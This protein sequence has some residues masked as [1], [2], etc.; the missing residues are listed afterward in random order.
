MFVKQQSGVRFDLESLEPRLLLSAVVPVA[1]PTEPSPFPAS[2]SSEIQDLGTCLQRP[3]TP[4]IAYDPADQLEGIFDGVGAQVGTLSP[5]VPPP[6]LPPAPA[7]EPGSLGSGSSETPAASASEAT[8][9]RAVVDPVSSSQSQGQP[10]PEVVSQAV[11]ASDLTIE[12]LRQQLAETLTIGLAPPKAALA[13]ASMDSAI[14]SLTFGPQQQDLGGST[15]PQL[16]PPGTALTKI[17]AFRTGLTS[18]LSAITGNLSNAA[19]TQNFPLLV[20]SSFASL[21][22]ASGLNTALQTEFFA[23]LDTF[24]RDTVDPTDE[25]FQAFINTLSP[26]VVGSLNLNTVG[27]KVSYDLHLKLS[28]TTTVNLRQVANFPDAGV[29]SQTVQGTAPVNVTIDLLL[30]FGVDQN[31]PLTDPQAFFFTVGNLEYHVETDGAAS[32][33][34]TGSA[35]A[36]PKGSLVMESALGIRFNAPAGS[37]P[38][39][40]LSDLQGAGASALWSSQTPTARIT[41]D[42][43]LPNALNLG[44]SILRFVGSK[45]VGFRALEAF[46]SPGEDILSLNGQL[47]FGDLVTVI[48]SLALR[49]LPSAA[50]AT[51]DLTAPITKIPLSGVKVFV[52][53]GWGTATPK[54]V[55]LSSGEGGVILANG[56]LAMDVEGE[57]TSLGL[58]D[59]LLRGRVHIRV[60]S[61]NS[62]VDEAIPP[63]EFLQLLGSSAPAARVTFD[64]AD[65]V[66]SVEGRMQL[67]VGS[68][69]V[70]NGDF[71]F[72]ALEEVGG[73]GNT[74]RLDVAVKNYEL[75]IGA[76]QGTDT[77]IGF[78][79][80]E[81]TLGLLLRRTPDGQT[82][83]A[84][85]TFGRIS[86]VGI[87]KL[88]FNG[89]A[90]VRFNTM[91]LV[92]ETIAVPGNTPILVQFT[93][94]EQQG[95]VANPYVCVA[96]TML[97]NLNYLG[98]IQ[99]GGDIAIE[100]FVTLGSTSNTTNSS[101]TL[102]LD[103]LLFDTGLGDIAAGDALYLQLRQN[104]SDEVLRLRSDGYQVLGLSAAV[105]GSISLVGGPRYKN[106]DNRTRTFNLSQHRRD[107]VRVLAAQLSTDLSASLG[108][109]FS[110][111][112]SEGEL[113]EGGMDRASQ[114]A[115]FSDVQMQVRK[116]V[117]QRTETITYR[118]AARDVMVFLGD[119]T[120]TVTRT[121]SGGANLQFPTD[122]KGV[123]IEHG[124]L[125]LLLEITPANL[126]T[127]TP[128]KHKYA[129]DARGSA[130]L[131]GFPE[132]VL[133]T[134]LR[135]RLNTLG[136]NPSGSGFR[137]FS[138]PFTLCG[139]LSTVTV[140]PDVDQGGTLENPFI[141]VDARVKLN[142]FDFVQASGVASFQK[143]TENNDSTAETR[144]VTSYR[145]HG[146]HPGHSKG[147][148]SDW[149]QL[150]P[151]RI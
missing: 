5:S 81:G 109:P 145:L 64:T 50:P 148:L 85:D 97:F 86:L 73:T 49:R 10:G 99:I 35:P 129:L 24:L 58:S 136:L 52:G 9:N 28:R 127:S 113:Q 25:S 55:L 31:P 139:T 53:T 67:T 128:A 147:S 47:T 95:T 84:L 14:S 36:D 74:F 3:S 75:F 143:F 42:M 7:E 91:G 72:K 26:L 23:R 92:N 57:V 43:P 59:F 94:P 119:G 79:V 15:F 106:F 76:G 51:A 83:M 93:A 121:P 135:V 101:E 105:N 66:T 20:T 115:N 137:L 146:H 60:N 122:A 100:R 30:T 134:D 37:A 62:R 16:P 102:S 87:D 108:G 118:V 126:A 40:K 39:A 19:F 32:V 68:Y 80:S 149:G 151:V 71:A 13:S 18:L 110:V 89:S 41:S 88:Y 6:L 150:D 130:A 8:E 22:N 11:G 44:G 120:V 61:T 27:T 140:D 29:N 104:I 48:G 77:A 90:H 54:G 112:F 38:F 141:R 45:S 107:N 70:L 123:K 82:R 138:D 142:L 114:N 1:L 144:E 132:I 17:S 103:P 33:N 133:Q 2:L 131:V 78:R 117:P 21:I 56:G 65:R 96:G 4:E 98:L 116:T 34:I 125:A 46:A 63:F 69:F 12:S 111:T 124:S